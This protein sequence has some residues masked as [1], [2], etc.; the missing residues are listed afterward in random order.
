MDNLM[1]SSIIALVNRTDLY[2]SHSGGKEWVKILVDP[3]PSPITH[4]SWNATSRTL[5]GISAKDGLYRLSIGKE[6]D[7]AIKK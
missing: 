2:Y 7:K 4:L 3:P 5:Y 1:P 6:I